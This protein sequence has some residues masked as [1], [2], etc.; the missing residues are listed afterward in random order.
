MMCCAEGDRRGSV[1][2]TKV[3]TTFIPRSMARKN[4]VFPSGCIPKIDIVRPS[5]ATPKKEKKKKK[6]EKGFLE[7]PKWRYKE[8]KDEKKK[9]KKK[10]EKEKAEKDKNKEK[11]NKNG[12]K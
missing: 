7:L 6:K 10:A 8:I 9:E 2:A 4:C 5:N 12:T 1:L 11:D 3:T